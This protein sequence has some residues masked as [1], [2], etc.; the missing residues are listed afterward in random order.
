MLELNIKLLKDN[1]NSLMKA[2]NLTQQQ[3]ADEIGMSQANLSKAL[4]PNEKKYFTVEQ[5]YRISQLFGISIDELIGS[6]AADSLYLSPQYIFT[7]LSKLL[8]NHCVKFKPIEIEEEVYQ[9]YR[10][11]DGWD[12]DIHKEKHKYAALYFPDFNDPAYVSDSEDEYFENRDI[13]SQTGNESRFVKMNETLKKLINVYTL[14]SK[15]SIPKDAFEMILKG[16]IEEL[17]D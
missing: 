16:Y 3:F 4:N 10:S 13:F 15:Q 17:K 12:C 11:E 6:R 9:P 7:F 14:Y 2:K 1:I 5:L 8:E